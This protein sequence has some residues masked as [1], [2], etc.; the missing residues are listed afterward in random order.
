MRYTSTP[1]RYSKIL[2]SILFILALGFKKSARAQGMEPIFPWNIELRAG[3]AIPTGD[4]SET[5]NIGADIGVKFGYALRERVFLR[6]DVETE[7]YPGADGLDNTQLWHYSA[8]AEHMFT[9]KG[10]TNWRVTGFGGLGATTVTF[11]DVSE[12]SETYFS[13]NYGIKVGRGISDNLDWFVGLMG[14]TVFANS[15]DNT[16]IGVFTTAPITLGL[17][18]RFNLNDKSVLDKMD[19]PPN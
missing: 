19:E 13:I 2:L 10:L 6:A 7:L 3:A 8:G 16:G 5:V 11:D 4:F 9:D 17:N 14:R 1:F 18:Y 12:L 15:Q